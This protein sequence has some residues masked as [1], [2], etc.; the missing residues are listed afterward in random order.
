LYFKYDTAVFMRAA[1]TQRRRR[2]ERGVPQRPGLRRGQARTATIEEEKAL[3]HPKKTKRRRAG[4]AP[5]ASAF[6]PAA[7]FVGLMVLW[8]AAVRLRDIPQYVLPAPGAMLAAFVRDAPAL[9]HHSAVTMKETAAGLLIAVAVAML[10][11]ILMDAFG[12]FREAVYPL[13]VVSQTIPVIVLAPLFI[14]YLGFGAAPKILTVVLMCYFPIAV[15]FMDGMRR[16]DVRLINLVRSFGANPV[17]I[18][19][20]VKIPMAL[21]FFFSGLRVAATYS[22]TGAVVGEWLSSDS[23]LGYYMLRVKNGYQLDRVFATILTIVLLSLF[24]NGVVRLISRLLLSPG[25]RRKD[26]RVRGHAKR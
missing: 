20:A 7:V 10:T 13:L 25:S 3:L 15:N 19:T 16:T 14:I 21:P 1:E 18:Y 22:I 4:G 11:A 5:T 12:K 8:E 23:G 26:G 24:M 6:L 2:I 9:L 17:Q